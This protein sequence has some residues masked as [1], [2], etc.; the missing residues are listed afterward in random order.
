MEFCQSN[1]VGTLI[2][3]CACNEKSMRLKYGCRRARKNRL[4]F[5]KKRKH[6]SRMHTARL[7]TICALVATRYQY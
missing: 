3:I 7:P 6:S 5:A 2:S 4:N 1:K